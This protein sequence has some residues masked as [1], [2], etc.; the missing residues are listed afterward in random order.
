MGDQPPT[1]WALLRS[2]RVLVVVAVTDLV[3]AWPAFLAV[4]L[5]S[6]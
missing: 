3:T 1:Q 2:L 4:R 5:V 6:A